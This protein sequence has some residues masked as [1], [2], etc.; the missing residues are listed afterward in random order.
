ME[1]KHENRVSWVAFDNDKA[2]AF[3][4]PDT[5][6]L[7]IWS[8]ICASTTNFQD[9]CPTTIENRSASR[10]SLPSDIRKIEKMKTWHAQRWIF[11]QVLDR[12]DSHVLIRCAYNQRGHLDEPE[13]WVLGKDKGGPQWSRHADCDRIERVRVNDFDVSETNIGIVYCPKGRAD[14]DNS[15]VASFFEKSPR[16]EIVATSIQENLPESGTFRIHVLGHLHAVVCHVKAGTSRGQEE[17]SGHVNLYHFPSRVEFSTDR[18]V[19]INNLQISNLAIPESGFQVWTGEKNIKIKPEKP[20]ATAPPIKV[21]HVEQRITPQLTRHNNLGIEPPPTPESEWLQ[22]E[23]VAVAADRVYA[24]S[25]IDGP[26]DFSRHPRLVLPWTSISKNELRDAD[27]I[28]D[29]VN[30]VK[31]LLVASEEVDFNL[32]LRLGRLLAIR[33]V[34]G[35]EIDGLLKTILKDEDVRTTFI[36]VWSPWYFIQRQL[37]SKPSYEASASPRTYPTIRNFVIH[38]CHCLDEAN[39]N[40][41]FEFLMNLHR[42][43]NTMVSRVA[44]EEL[45]RATT[46]WRNSGVATTC[47]MKNELLW[48]CHATGMPIDRSTKMELRQIVVIMRYHFIATE[49]LKFNYREDEKLLKWVA[50][51]NKDVFASQHPFINTMIY[52]CKSTQPDLSDEVQRGKN[53]VRNLLRS[54]LLPSIYWDHPDQLRLPL[55]LSVPHL[56]EYLWNEPKALNF[57]IVYVVRLYGSS[58]FPMTLRIDKDVPLANP[59]ALLDFLG[60]KLD[61]FGKIL[62]AELSPMSEREKL[63]DAP[64]KDSATQYEAL[65]VLTM[66]EII[67]DKPVT[68]DGHLSNFALDD[69]RSSTAPSHPSHIKQIDR[70]LRLI[71]RPD[72]NKQHNHEYPPDLKFFLTNTDASVPEL[73]VWALAALKH[74][75]IPNPEAQD[76][77]LRNFI[78]D[79][80]STAYDAIGLWLGLIISRVPRDL[81]DATENKEWKAHAEFLPLLQLLSNAKFAKVLMKFFSVRRITVSFAK[82]PLKTRWVAASMGE[83]TIFDYGDESDLQICEDVCGVRRCVKIVKLAAGSVECY[84]RL[85]PADEYLLRPL[86]IFCASGHEVNQHCMVMEL[87]TLGES[88]APPCLSNWLRNPNRTAL[89]NGPEQTHAFRLDER[90]AAFV[91]GSVLRGL[92]RLHRGGMY[93]AALDMT[94][95][96]ACRTNMNWN[97][98]GDCGTCRKPSCTFASRDRQN[99]VFKLCDCVQPL[100]AADATDL[101]EKQKQNAMDFV[102]IWLRLL[103]GFDDLQIGV[104]AA[105]VRSLSTVVDLIQLLS[106]DNS[107]NLVNWY[108][109]SNVNDYFNLEGLSSGPEASHEQEDEIAVSVREGPS[110]PDQNEEHQ[111]HED[112]GEQQRLTAG[113]VIKIMGQ[114]TVDDPVEFVSPGDARR[115]VVVDDTLLL[116]ALEVAKPL[117]LKRA[118]FGMVCASRLRET[119]RM[120]PTTTTDLLPE[121]VKH[122]APLAAFMLELLSQ[123]S[124]SPVDTIYCSTLMRHV[125][126]P[127]F[128]WCLSHESVP[129]A[130]DVGRTHGDQ[131]I[132]S[133]A[134]LGDCW[135]SVL[136]NVALSVFPECDG[137]KLAKELNE[138]VRNNRDELLQRECIQAHSIALKLEPF[139]K[140]DDPNMEGLIK[141][142]NSAIARGAT[143]KESTQVRLVRLQNHW[144]VN[145]TLDSKHH[146]IRGV[147][148]HATVIKTLM[149]APGGRQQWYV[150]D[151]EYKGKWNLVDAEY[152]STELYSLVHVIT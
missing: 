100:Y 111:P 152:K 78:R 63:L 37:L 114:F 47:P 147:E 103:G 92:V 124:E 73:S 1:K 22:S 113:D 85:T 102:K 79:H 29:E 120:M 93:H 62:K 135:I 86:T 15:C 123:P 41:L 112:E 69:D 146:V 88:E 18:Y 57:F 140:R 38:C 129:T 28:H 133:T 34:D 27:R 145:K 107:W 17:K 2:L 55:E 118:C 72:H 96:L 138:W 116:K 9:L 11:M 150:I 137:K 35:N 74:L 94:N 144:T 23:A 8:G 5:K 130:G 24:A 50:E 141:S 80:V 32:S 43:N 61:S 142:F 56:I 139:A 10:R 81:F 31:N 44:C 131:I 25:R 125:L 110:R 70:L 36:A 77:K 95:I 106:D 76:G 128:D 117:V 121:A 26:D 16:N 40:R 49:C 48:L 89:A 115:Q 7:E 52:A 13:I 82:T 6:P 60:D 105:S 14:K 101:A 53:Q 151:P 91:A 67:Q 98:P 104:L 12:D 109:A 99:Y 68:S 33:A 20:S 54:T 30:A 39:F 84:Q 58:I 45:M 87:W 122:S 83:Y 46:E 126:H 19:D 75:R 59:V 66:N 4:I 65:L 136:V 42:C 64:A 71:W 132:R 51:E 119:K 143:Q 148:G 3:W 134:E 149:T 21:V 108:S 90:S 97:C 127:H